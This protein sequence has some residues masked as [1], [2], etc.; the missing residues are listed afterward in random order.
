[1][2]NLKLRETQ[3]EDKISSAK[4]MYENDLIYQFST[5]NNSR[6]YK[7]IRS[8]TGNSSIPLTV[9]LDSVHATA[10]LVKASLFNT[11]FHSIFT[12]SSFELPSLESLSTPAS[13]ICDFT[14]SSSEV[15]ETLSS[16][17]STKAMGIDGIG[18]CLLK[19]C[20]HV[21]YLP[22]H[23]LFCLILEQHSIPQEW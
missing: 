2:N 12:H 11:H 19:E 20:A 3:L 9:D 15:F 7:Y 13:T 6:I 18:P 8:V 23:Y 10:D 22:F 21:L 1:M 17:D 16:L 4:S 14:I 5:S